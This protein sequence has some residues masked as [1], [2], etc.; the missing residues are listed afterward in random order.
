MFVF[1]NKK[2]FKR[3]KGDLIIDVNYIIYILYTIQEKIQLI[4]FICFYTKIKHFE[5]RADFL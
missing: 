5:Q 2:Y 3:E 4:N 1:Y